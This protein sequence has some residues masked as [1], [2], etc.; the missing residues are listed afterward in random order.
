M[1]GRPTEGCLPAARSCL[2]HP[3]LKKRTHAGNERAF[4]RFH[5]ATLPMPT[6]GT[7][8]A[9]KVG[10]GSQPRPRKH[11]DSVHQCSSVQSGHWHS[12]PGKE[13]ALCKGNPCPVQAIKPHALE[14][15]ARFGN[16]IVD[17]EGM[18]GHLGTG[19]P[20]RT[21]HWR[22]VFC[23]QLT[24][25]R[26]LPVVVTHP[27]QSETAKAFEPSRP[28]LWR[29]AGARQDQ[30]RLTLPRAGRGRAPPPHGPTH[31]TSPGLARSV[32]PS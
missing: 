32:N 13:V 18:F 7:L 24:P 17:G 14:H 25:Q 5:S 2:H 20:Q 11:L 19:P 1:A 30:S 10:P 23:R 4:Q 28:M 27:G 26:G 21:E 9:C 31:V 6:Q 22:Y 12:A 3:S 29:L 15:R 16:V 8:A